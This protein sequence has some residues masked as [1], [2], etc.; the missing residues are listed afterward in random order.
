MTLTLI[1]CL[2]VFFLSDLIVA[3]STLLCVDSLDSTLSVC[4]DSISGL[5]TT[6]SPLAS[7]PWNVNASTILGDKAVLTGSPSVTQTNGQVTI[8]NKWCFDTNSLAPQGS[9]AIV[10]D[11]L[12]P[13][14]SSVHWR[15]S[16]LGTSSAPWSVPIQTSWIFNDSSV[17][18]AWAPWDRGSVK[19]WDLNWVDP[20]QPSDVLPGGWWDGTYRIGNGRDGSDFVITGLATVLSANPDLLDAGI[21]IHL[22][23]TD[24]PMDTHLYLQGSIGGLSFSREHYRISSFAPVEL[25]M[26]IVGHAAD[27]RSALAFSV[28]TWPAYW[29]PHNPEVYNTCAGTGSYSWWLGSL[30]QTPSYESMAYKVNWDLSGRFFP[31]MGM[32]LPPVAPGVEW[33]NDPEGT[34]PRANV[35]FESIGAWYRQMAD[36]GFSDLSY[37]NVN[38]Y[39]INVVLPPSQ[40]SSS[41]MIT[42]ELPIVDEA[43]ISRLFDNVAQFILSS[44]SRNDENDLTSSSLSPQIC[45]STWQNAST[46]LA[47]AFPD[48]ALTKSW[49]EIN[50]RVVKGA[51][52]SWQNAIVVDPGVQG[53]HAFMLEQ[54]ARHI[55]YEDAF[56]GYII[57]RSDWM[58]VSS[59]QRDDGVTFI[60]EAVNSTGSGIGASLKV[61]YQR[62]VSDLRAVLDAGPAALQSL[63]KRL[64][65]SDRMNQTY[66]LGEMNGTGLMMMNLYGNARLDQFAPYDG[67]F[68]EGPLISGAGLLGIMSPTILWTY[69]SS[70]CC[71]SSNWSDFYFQRHVLM[72]VMPMLPFPGTYF[73]LIS[74]SM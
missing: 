49:D 4:V 7:V 18:K 68:S 63:R 61:S 23:P 73:T 16:I 19:G 48:A 17:L 66:Q 22:A 1:L 38:E 31:Y 42:S 32:F 2:F 3:S 10:T 71:R 13:K 12:S 24:I 21:S 36:R 44:P 6:V 50:K 60:P 45:E 26:E 28:S 37:A 56:V 5:I 47:E 72:N 39:G 40:L 25:D 54:L 11:V 15:V 52:I 67:I 62:M 41:R 74:S 14:T 55:V 64:A 30:D 46:C 43:Y 27:W 69:D 9:C 57:D 34:Q 59:L 35:T 53:Y 20:L 70:E 29:E 65:T 8:V 51:Y 33:L 58:D